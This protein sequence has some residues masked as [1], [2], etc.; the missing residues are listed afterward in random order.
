[1]ENLTNLEVSILKKK[2][3]IRQ[4]VLPYPVPGL[5]SL[6]RRPKY[7]RAAIAIPGD[8]GDDMSTTSTQDD[9]MY[10][11]ASSAILEDE[12]SS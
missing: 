5:S 7:P 1:M 6:S 10:L 4:F 9:D 11:M 8:T 3:D 2:D 12:D